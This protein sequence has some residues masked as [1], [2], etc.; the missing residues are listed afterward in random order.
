[1]RELIGLAIF[2]VIVGWL[3]FGWFKDVSYTGY[4]YA[5]VNNYDFVTKQGG[6]KDLDA[7]RGWVNGQAYRD[8]DN[9]Y[10]YECG[11]N[12]RPD[13]T[14]AGPDRCETTEK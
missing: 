14:I 6:F 11:K 13:E 4:F 5:N 2:V 8:S 3:F 12:C 1:M 10:D 7:C 9:S